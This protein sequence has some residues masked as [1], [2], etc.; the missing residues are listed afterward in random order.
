MEASDQTLAT[1]G[2]TLAATAVCPSPM[3]TA[4]GCLTLPGTHIGS[5]ICVLA[6]WW[7]QVIP[8]M[9]KCRSSSGAM[10]TSLKSSRPTPNSR[11]FAPL[12]FGCSYM[13]QNKASEP[14]LKVGLVE[15]RV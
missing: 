7:T 9:S 8:L 11:L 3:H 2:V 1:R 13:L 6:L 5:P 4:S 10:Q 12:T 15:A 14:S